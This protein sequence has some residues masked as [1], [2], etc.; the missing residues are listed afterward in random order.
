MKPW[1]NTVRNVCLIHQEIVFITSI[2]VSFAVYWTVLVQYQ[3]SSHSLPYFS[4][5]S[6]FGFYLLWCNWRSLHSQKFFLIWKNVFFPWKRIIIYKG[7]W[8]LNKNGRNH[9]LRPGKHNED[10]GLGKKKECSQI[11]SDDIFLSFYLI[12]LLFA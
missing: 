5:H 10:I 6:R 9:L 11:I 12:L 4:F 3:I 7:W 1:L 2:T 8:V